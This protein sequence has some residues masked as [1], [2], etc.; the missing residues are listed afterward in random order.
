MGQ[1]KKKP[2][3]AQRK[4]Q[5]RQEKANAA[6]QVDVGPGARGAHSG[7]SCAGTDV[8]TEGSS[9]TKD[10]CH[11]VGHLRMPRARWR[12]LSRNRQ[13]HHIT[14]RDLLR[15]LPS[16]RR[17]SWYPGK[18]Y[19]GLYW[20]MDYGPICGLVLRR[21]TSLPP[22]LELELELAN[23]TIGDTNSEICA[24]LIYFTRR[25]L[26]RTTGY[27]PA[28]TED[29]GLMAV[30]AVGDVFMWCRAGSTYRNMD[31]IFPIVSVSAF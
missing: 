26:I 1:R 28:L 16:S 30:V 7:E 6:P 2:S 5:W 9:R 8:D 31:D 4:R 23:T 25:P 3:G 19:Q 21:P 27:R 13:I 11:L 17:F 12:V 14:V 22:K 24:S 29:R 18:K 10:L 15:L 20:G